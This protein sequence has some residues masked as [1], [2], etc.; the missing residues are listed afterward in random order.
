MI[1]QPDG[2]LMTWAS[3]LPARGGEELLRTASAS[4]RPP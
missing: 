4:S 2:G 1:A 3:L